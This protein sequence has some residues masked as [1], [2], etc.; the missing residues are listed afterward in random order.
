[1]DPRYTCRF[2]DIRLPLKVEE[3]TR[4]TTRN[5]P[6]LEWESYIFR[7]ATP[8]AGPESNQSACKGFSDRFYS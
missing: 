5:I 6:V 3:T 1:M 4:K 8:Q 2:M 7:R